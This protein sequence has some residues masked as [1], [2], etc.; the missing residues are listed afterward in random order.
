[1]EVFSLISHFKYPHIKTTIL[2]ILLFTVLTSGQSKK[3]TFTGVVNNDIRQIV[4]MPADNTKPFISLDE[5]PKKKSIL[6]AGVFSAILPG[7]GEFYSEQ[8]I[9]S[10]VFLGIEAAAIIVGVINNKKGDD[11]TNEFQSYANMNWSVARYA[12]WTLV[13]ARS[14]NS[15]VDPTTFNVFDGTGKVV[16]SELNRLE[17]EIGQGTNYYSH[18]L[19]GYGEQQYYEM[20]GKYPQFNP[21]WDDFGNENTAYKYGDPVTAHFTYYS[22]ERG[23]AN[24]F[25][26]VASKA[27]VVIVTNHVISMFDAIWSAAS[28]NKKLQVNMSLKQDQIGY[29]IEYSTV[30]NLKYNF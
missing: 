21:G 18:R 2:I 12:R 25:Y 5:S 10:A 17:N 8:Y 27:V 16:W 7:S 3:I 6:L 13:H 15:D 24:D 9:K 14:I 22:G 4:N 20:I 19:A 11:K 1:M 28:F 26:N 29:R 23:K 30:L